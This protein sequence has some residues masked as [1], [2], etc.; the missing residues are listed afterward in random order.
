MRLST[1]KAVINYYSKHNY[2]YH[3]HVLH[4][5]LIN[6]TYENIQSRHSLIPFIE[7][8]WIKININALILHGWIAMRSL[9]ANDGH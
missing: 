2:M 4:S 8:Y 3:I 1:I 9:F 7:T 5:L 6:I